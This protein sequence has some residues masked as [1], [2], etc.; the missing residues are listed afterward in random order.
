[1]GTIQVVSLEIW[2]ERIL[3]TLPLFRN[4]TFSHIYH[5]ENKEEDRFSKLA[6]EKFSG[7]IAFNHWEADN[8]GPTHNLKLF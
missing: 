7:S 5:E 3:E 4:I 2:K 1:M 8:E 6:L